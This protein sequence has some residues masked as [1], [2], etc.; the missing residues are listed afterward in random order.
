VGAER[1]ALIEKVSDRCTFQIGNALDLPFKEGEFQL[2]VSTFAFHEIHVPDQTVLLNEVVRVLTP[3][4]AFLV[5]DLF[6]GSFVKK[7]KVKSM[8]E[9]LQKIEL[10]GIEGVKHKTLKETG[11][12]L[13]RFAHI[14]GTAY[15]S[16]RKA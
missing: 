4:G 10:L 16:G 7:Y 11:V 1:N 6:A 9:L 12:N 2:V 13:G 14:W 15:L 3:G 8:P 5:C